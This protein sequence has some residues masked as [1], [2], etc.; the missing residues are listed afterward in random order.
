MSFLEIA[1]FSTESAL[2][3]QDAGADRI[4]FCAGLDVG[5]T[6]PSLTSFQ[7]LRSQV[8]R[9]P[10]YIMIR[11]RGGDFAYSPEEFARM[12]SEIMNFK[13]LGSIDGFVFGVLDN[14]KHVCKDRNRQL[15]E[16][17]KPA[18]CTFH[19][20]FDEID[21]T[22]RLQALEDVVACGFQAI[23]TS[24]GAANAEAG[25]DAI[26]DLVQAARSRITIIA[27]GGVRALNVRALHART[28]AAYFHSSAI[29]NG[30]VAS[31]DEVLSLKSEL[32]KQ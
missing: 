13:S 9:I 20:A 29:R 16:L 31:R 27:G 1:C 14:N 17:A 11:P 30:E 19:R 32:L 2:I 23:L 12:K 5:G 7:D 4:E 6:T 24:G 21:A 22:A 3:A 8:T 10:I 26:A 25:S 15:V 28:D 18:V